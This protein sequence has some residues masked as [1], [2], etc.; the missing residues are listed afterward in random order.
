MSPPGYFDQVEEGWIEIYPGTQFHFGHPL[1]GEI[2]VK[3][4]AHSLSRLCRYNGHTTRHYSVAEHACHLSDWVLCEG[5][6]PLEAF[7]ALH[8]DDAE[9]IIG[10]LPKPIKVTMPEFVA[11]ETIMD[12]AIAKEFETIYPFP[13]HIKEG[14]V[15][16]IKDERDAV[17]MPS[18]HSWGVDGLEKIGVNFWNI[19][20]RWPWYV[21]RQFLKRHNRLWKQ[22]HGC[23]FEARGWVE[24]PDDIRL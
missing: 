3:A 18:P 7:T 17:M 5:G 24:D 6:S 23:A 1:P 16:I 8:H 14:D 20:G 4:I 19:L 13:A 12:K 11:L 22:I 2:A 10:D 15:R 21:K 9:Y